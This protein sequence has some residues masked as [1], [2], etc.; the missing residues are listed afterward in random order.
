MITLTGRIKDLIIR[1]GEN[2]SPAEVEVALAAHPEVA[3]SAVVGLPDERWG[4][5]VAA[6]VCTH[7]PPT[8]SLERELAEH[9][10][11]RLTPVKVPV[12]WF[13]RDELPHTPS[14]KVQKYLL[15]DS[16]VDT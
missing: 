2:I 15:R 8:E 12:R 1:G 9:C 16:L 4:E 3:E 5:I 11:S 10:L 14:G 13:F 6:V 7:R